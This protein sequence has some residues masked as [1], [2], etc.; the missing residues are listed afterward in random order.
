MIVCVLY[1]RFELLAALGDRRALISEPAALA[2]EAGREQLVGEVSA[3][4]EA[5]GIVRGMRLGEAMS[6]CPAL[7]LVPPDPEGV[8]SLWNAVLDRVEGIGAAVESDQAG[9][10]FFEAAG[11]EG[12]HCGDLAGVLAAARRKLGA[13][14][15]FG[16]APSRFA[17]YAAALQARPRRRGRTSP[18][19]A[20]GTGPVYMS[21]A[22]VVDEAALRDFLAPLPVG[23]LRTRPELQALPE[24]LEQ[25]G[26]RT[27]GDVAGLPARAV[28]ERFGHPGL[29]A[30]DLARGR[31]LPLEPRRPPEPV[32]ER[33]ELPEAAS[34][35][36]LERALE[37]LIARVLARRERRGR[38]LRALAV[39]ARFVAGGTWRTAVT[40]RH[41]TADPA[42]IRLALGPKLAELPAPSESLT[43]EVEAF[44]PPA[45]DQG[46]L[47]DEAAEVRRG[48]LGEAVRQ[49]RQ[50]AGG[51]AALRV[52]DL[53][54][55]SRIP[56][57]RAVLAPFPDAPAS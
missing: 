45:Q 51:E 36:Q 9:A 7:R 48:R 30:L 24:V 29:L 40:L 3:P 31:D 13:G 53:D 25:L 22:V 38:S 14:A 54:P 21:G 12:I 4:A 39:S 42:R 44:G 57:R 26:L 11:L 37:L 56:E 43:L 2:P 5:F 6:R 28:S 19:A 1:P 50:A 23:I 41:A 18:A 34:G 46:R 47:L 15:R 20:H 10:A 49:A 35:Q 55:D 32:S 8:R 17:A 27:L 16:A 33:L 52:L